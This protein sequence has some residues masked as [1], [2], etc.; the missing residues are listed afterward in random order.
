MLSVLLQTTEEQQLLQL[1]DTQLFKLLKVALP[2]S[3]SYMGHA[4][5]GQGFSVLAS[6]ILESTAGKAQSSTPKKL[7]FAAVALERKLSRQPGNVINDETRV[8]EHNKKVTTTY[9]PKPPRQKEDDE[10]PSSEEEMEVRVRKLMAEVKQL[11]ENFKKSPTKSHKSANRD[12]V[13]YDGQEFAQGKHAVLI[14]LLKE[15]QGKFSDNKR[16]T[17]NECFAFIKTG[18]CRRGDGCKFEHPEGNDIPPPYPT[19]SPKRH[20]SDS[21]RSTQG[22]RNC[23]TAKRTGVCGDSH[24]PDYHGQFDGRALDMCR[25]IQDGRPCYRQWL[26]MGCAFNHIAETRQDRRHERRGS[27]RADRFRGQILIEESR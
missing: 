9:K 6:S 3:M 21:P 22:E 15:I 23:E 1:A 20:R 27:S 11:K 8:G 26:K 16:G 4:N 24:C 19:S 12:D 2:E 18:A 25:Y 5:F 10:Q 13:E 14:S 7:G 17:S